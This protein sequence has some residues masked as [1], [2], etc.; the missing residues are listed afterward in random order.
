MK[1]KNK[2][3][4]S[5]EDKHLFRQAVS[6]VNR[7]RSDTVHHDLPRPRPIPIQRKLDDAQVIK[8]M[9]SDHLDIADVETGEELIFSRQGISP[10]QMRKLRRGQFSIGGQLDLHG[11]TS[12]TARSALATFIHNCQA[13]GIRCVRVIH[14]KGHGS[15]QKIPVLK[16]KLNRWLRQ[17]D[18]VLAFCSAKASD[19]GTGAVYV[20]IKKAT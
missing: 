14:G 3:G 7:L 15:R 18:E 13:S 16:N 11:M 12:D 10:Q 6:G 2:T 9:M 1:K 5:A 17:K 8:D 19:G 4:I 20:L